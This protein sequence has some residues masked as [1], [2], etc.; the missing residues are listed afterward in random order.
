MGD[1][2]EYNQAEQGADEAARTAGRAA[3]KT[4]GSARKKIAKRTAR[5]GM[6]KAGE[7]T[8]NTAQRGLH[9]GMQGLSR[10]GGVLKA[11]AQRLGKGVV[12]FAG[13]IVTALIA[14]KIGIIVLLILLV[15]VPVMIFFVMESQKAYAYEGWGSF[16]ESFAQNSET[17]KTRN[18]ITLGGLTEEE[19]KKLVGD[20]SAGIQG[21]IDTGA[22]PIDISLPPEE[23]ERLKEENELRQENF[24]EVSTEQE[25]ARI[26]AYVTAERDSILKSPGDAGFKGILKFFFGDKD[27]SEA[28]LTFENDPKDFEDLLKLVRIREEDSEGVKNRKRMII[29][30]LRKVGSHIETINSHIKT[31]SDGMKDITDKMVHA[32][33]TWP[34]VKD[35]PMEDKLFKLLEPYALS[36]KVLYLIDKALDENEF[37]DFSRYGELAN[38]TE[39]EKEAFKEEMMEKF[40]LQAIP[41]FMPN[42]KVVR[43][44]RLTEETTS[45][46]SCSETEDGCDCDSESDTTITITPVY[47]LEYVDKWDQTIISPTVEREVIKEEWSYTKDCSGVHVSDYTYKRVVEP[48]P[49]PPSGVDIDDVETREVYG[50]ERKVS[51]YREK[52]VTND[53]QTA[54]V[55]YKSDEVKKIFQ[56]IYGEEAMDILTYDIEH[57][58]YLSQ[59]AGQFLNARIE[60]ARAF[61][62]D[63]NMLW[64]SPFGA[65]SNI[66]DI[67]YILDKLPDK[68]LTQFLKEN[69]E[70]I[71]MAA[72]ANGIPAPAMIAQLIAEIGWDMK[73]ISGTNNLFNIT[74]DGPAGTKWYNDRYWRV[75]SDYKQSI[76]DYIHLITSEYPY[77]IH[78]AQTG[79]PIAF[80]TALQSVPDHMYCEPSSPPYE[81]FLVEIMNDFHLVGMGM[82]TIVGDVAWPVANPKV[83]NSRF[84]NRTA[85]C[86]GCSSFHK[87][88]DIPSPLGTEVY[89]F[90]DGVVTRIERQ[91][92]YGYIIF[93]N[94]Q[95]GLMSFY[96]HL[97]DGSAAV[98]V[99]QTVSAGQKIALSGNTGRGTGPHLHFGILNNGRDDDPEKYLPKVYTYQ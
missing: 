73:V 71:N 32:G 72:P 57:G 47:I 5:K 18:Y 45:S 28:R 15:F 59:W 37:E 53:S 48:I 4:A 91:S 9:R 70:Y 87:G 14:S 12:Q 10:A 74:G 52:I 44:L 77:A 69:I 1:W 19:F 46:R 25:R 82:P 36:W 63:M 61:G 79:G 98:Q 30:Q 60:V 92:G 26:K 68:P 24:T 22:L 8:K 89:A 2:D 16:I 58:I 39:E 27:E 38:M 3:K 66:A 40:I 51:R 35:Y 67:Q 17:Y 34:V 13:R 50:E 86:S 7:T 65:G 96:A 6:E 42:F 29:D 97:T 54:T 80:V 88:V 56:E 85:P 90:S 21:A 23:Q 33:R 76:D 94:H 95:N 81:Q 31:N 78:A 11:G 20:K 75:Y 55:I 93:I 84:G 41:K 49:A 83:I 43:H 64:Y 99:G 62:L